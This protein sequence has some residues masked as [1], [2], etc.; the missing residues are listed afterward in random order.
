MDTSQKLSANFTLGELLYSNTAISKG[1]SN[2][3]NAKELANLKQLVETFLQPL[4]DDIKL[5]IRINSGFRSQ[6]LNKAI[7]GSS[8]TSAHCHGLAVDIVCPAYKNGNVREFCL[9]VADFV[10]RKN[11]KFD[12]IIYEKV[13]GA[14]WCHF[15]IAH[16]D[17]RKRGQLLTIHNRKT[18]VGF[19][20]V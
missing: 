11:I 13:G 3:P 14:K 15:G 1:I 4:R 17:G 8:T 5:P 19:K 7:P 16:Q 2:A 6:A 9:Y 12:Q 20:N 10:K 18:T